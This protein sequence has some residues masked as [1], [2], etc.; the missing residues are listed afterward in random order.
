[1]A[2]FWSEF[3]HSAKRVSI[4]WGFTLITISLTGKIMIVGEKSV[5]HQIRSCDTWKLL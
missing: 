1:M 4:F 2:A 3:E 5:I